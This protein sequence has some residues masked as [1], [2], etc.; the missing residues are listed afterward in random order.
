VGNEKRPGAAED[1]EHAE[2]KEGRKEEE[3]K[4]KKEK[5]K[6]G[7]LSTPEARRRRWRAEK[8]PE[9]LHEK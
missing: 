7:E 6:R 4:R 1:G 5:E 3:E 2:K 9:K 8:R